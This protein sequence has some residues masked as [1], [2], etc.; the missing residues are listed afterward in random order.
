MM[1]AVCVIHEMGCDVLM[2]SVDHAVQSVGL[3]I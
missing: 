1:T 2:T 3:Y